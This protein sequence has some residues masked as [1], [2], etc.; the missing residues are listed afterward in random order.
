MHVLQ[1][2]MTIQLEL[3]IVRPLI[4]IVN[5]LSVDYLHKNV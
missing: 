2:N 1:D 4:D 3:Y 5:V